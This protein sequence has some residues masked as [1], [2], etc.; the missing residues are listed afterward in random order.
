MTEQCARCGC[1]GIHLFYLPDAW[2][3]GICHGCALGGETEQRF[4]THFGEV[5]FVADGDAGQGHAKT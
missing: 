5:R 4:R 2:D 1:S 3:G